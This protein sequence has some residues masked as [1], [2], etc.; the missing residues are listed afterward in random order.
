MSTIAL[1]KKTLLAGVAAVGIAM[2]VSSQANATAF[3]YAAMEVENFR[4]N[5]GQFG[6]FDTFEFTAFPVSTTLNGNTVSTA[7]QVSTVNGGSTN[8]AQ[9]IQ[10]SAPF[11]ADN[12][13]FGA[14][15]PQFLNPTS[16]YVLADTHMTD[17][18]LGAGLGNFGTQSGAHLSG[19]T[20]GA[21]NTSTDNSMSWNFNVS[22]GE[23]AAQGGNM[24]L[25]SIFDVTSRVNVQSNQANESGRA[26]LN[27]TIQ[28]LDDQGNI[29][30][31]EVVFDRNLNMQFSPNAL[32]DANSIFVDEYTF[33]F[34]IT[35]A[36]NYTYNIL[37]D[38]SAQARSVPE[39][40]TAT[41]F[42]AGLLAAGG[43]TSL[44]RR[45]RQG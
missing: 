26:T 39:P 45:R 28:L 41:L 12:S 25:T 17:T 30:D 1:S 5:T 44:R 3:A 40:M 8:Q 20:T 24:V 37:F 4:L 42:G 9:Q 33:D 22:A 36:G 6:G 7:Q 19:V 10:G 11:A 35:A 16:T 27:F 14:N 43:L 31:E 23:L 2:S 34:L 29:I 18:R 13:Y 32:G 21:A 38:S 15:E